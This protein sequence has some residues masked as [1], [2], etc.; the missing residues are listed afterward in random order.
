MD[1]LD[2]LSVNDLDELSVD[3]LNSLSVNDLDEISVDDLDYLSVD[4]LDYLD[5][6]FVDN[7]HD[8]SVDELDDLSAD[9]P[10]LYDLSVRRVLFFLCSYYNSAPMVQPTSKR[11]PFSIRPTEGVALLMCQSLSPLG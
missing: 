6:I 9:D 7:L 4:D 1:D 2:E 3:D 11:F 5:E 8:I 10:S